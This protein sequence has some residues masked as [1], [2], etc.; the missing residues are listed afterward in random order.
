MSLTARV[1]LLRHDRGIRS[2]KAA[3]EEVYLEKTAN[4]GVDIPS[5]G[6]PFQTWAEETE[7]AQLLMVDSGRRSAM[8]TSPNVDDDKPHSQPAEAFPYS[9]RTQEEGLGLSVVL[10]CSMTYVNMSSDHSWQLPSGTIWHSCDKH[11]HIRLH[12]GF[13]IHL[14]VVAIDLNLLQIFRNDL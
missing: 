11:S 4:D 1:S 12:I 14:K 6:N 3:L 9:W 10:G 2:W 13:S 7:R 8:V 5:C